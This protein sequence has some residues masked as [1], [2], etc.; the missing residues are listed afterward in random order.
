MVASAFARSAATIVYAV[1]R[2]SWIFSLSSGQRTLCANGWLPA[3][4]TT[5]YEISVPGLVQSRHLVS[6]IQKSSSELKLRYFIECIVALAEPAG[7]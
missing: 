1:E 5:A 7:N 3:L 4:S 6:I 2:R